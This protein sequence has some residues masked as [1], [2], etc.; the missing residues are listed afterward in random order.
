MNYPYVIEV[1]IPLPIDNTFDYLIS[2]SEFELISVGC[3]VVVSFGSKKLYTGIVLSKSKNVNID[4]NLKEIK[5]IV[6]EIPCV[7]VSQINFY[8]WISNYYMCPIGT[9]FD[10][11]LP[12]SLLIRSETVVKLKNDNLHD[13]L[14]EKS[15]HLLEVINQN[16]EIHVKDLSRIFGNS[17]LKDVNELI[18]KDIIDIKQEVYSTYIEKYQIVYSLNSKIKFE[19][20]TLRTD[21]Q[22]DV[23]DFFLKNN[24][25]QY[26]S[27]STILDALKISSSVIDGLVKKELL[28]KN[29]LK[30]DRLKSE[31]EIKE[32]KINLSQAQL[33][34]FDNI[35]S[36]FQE[37]NVVNLMGVTSSGKTEVYISLVK[38]YLKD[39]KSVLFLV[40][41]I[42]LTTQL[43]LRFKEFFSSE[44]IVYHSSISSNIRYEIWNELNS[45]KSPKIILGVR[46]SIFL[47]HKNLGL[48]IVDEEHENSYK[49][50]EPNPRYNARDC[51]IYLAKFLNINCLLGSATPSLE[52]YYNSINN[53]FSLVKLNER[54]GN[55]SPP[56]IKL[57]EPSKSDKSLFSSELLKHIENTL[58]SDNQ[59]ILF[60]NRR[61]YSTYL[62]CSAC[63]HVNICPNCDVSLTYHLNDNL[64]KCHYC[65]FSRQM[66]INCN[67]CSLTTMKKCGVGTQTLE[68]EFSKLFPSIKLARFDYDTTRSK[69][70]LKK[71]INDFQDKKFQV[72]IGTQ[73]I[74][75][76]LNFRNVDLVGVIE[77]DFLLNYPDYRSH[78][79]Y[80][81]LIKQVSG[82]AGR[83]SSRGKVVIQ[84]NYKNHYIHQRIIDNNYQDFYNFQLNQR[85]EFNYP[86][87][88]KLI[89]ISLKSKKIEILNI[90][91]EWFYSAIKNMI[92]FQILGPEFPIISRI[93]NFYIKDILIK[94]DDFS[95]L[96]STKK[97]LSKL[98]KRFAEYPE[99]KSVKIS[100]DIDPYN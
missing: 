69:K 98:L 19:S 80:F 79:K 76:G 2:E 56:E 96:K 59:V 22:K 26:F 40:P 36:D 23:I 57:I 54:Y 66:S 94:I 81:Q 75:K 17:I 49:Q 55:F 5:F 84:T 68:S 71:I 47:P 35:K 33:K 29:K 38:E 27:K 41:E 63:N 53:K 83:S 73:M 18:H 12:K 21:K 45:N 58:S 50:I 65:G 51:A 46:S 91:A 25:E 28:I 43:V 34:A 42:A 6:D 67:S 16:Q 14:S 95:Y 97:N 8:R 30:V 64:E 7:G 4:F 86:P 31:F 100:V 37:T 72:L 70:N 92:D 74:A 88:S 10:A 48:I 77:S 78:E 89:K 39:G 44:L 62:K 11:A 90:S 82:R 9:V 32:K 87:F 13:S 61:G 52:T 85:K 60:R 3:R 99:F 93:N 20:I 15:I 24:Q 1:V